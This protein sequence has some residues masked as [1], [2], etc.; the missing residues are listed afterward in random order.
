MPQLLIHESGERDEEV[1]EVDLALGEMTVGRSEDC[2]LYLD[3]QTISRR[4]ASLASTSQG[5]VLTDLG[6]VNGTW[7]NGKKI[8]RHLLRH[9]DFICFGS[10]VAIFS[11]PPDPDATL[12]IDVKALFDAG[13]NTAA[14]RIADFMR[15]EPAMRPD[16]PAAAH[17]PPVVTPPPPTEP[18][19]P[20][21]PPPLPAAPKPRSAPPPRSA[22]EH[23]LQRSSQPPPIRRPASAAAAPA[24][25]PVARAGDRRFAGFWIR[26]GAWLVDSVILGIVSVALT[27]AVGIAVGALG[28]QAPWLQIYL[29][30]IT[31]AVGFLLPAFYILIGWARYGKTLGKKV[32]GLRIVRENGA[33]LGFGGALIRMLGYMLSSLIFGIGFLMVAFTDRKRGLHDMVAGTVVVRER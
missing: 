17:P 12:Q 27:F 33:P 19:P 4:H 13:H 1:R 23:N 2:D 8:N 10:A 24:V 30:P 21:Q 29:V 15:D 18:P 9:E 31:A 11:E 16:P 32:C 20:P 5:Y 14:S 7:V 3:N 22:G 28:S 25:A 26:V 6:S